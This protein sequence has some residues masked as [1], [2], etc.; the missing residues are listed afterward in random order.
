[1][2]EFIKY[3]AFVIFTTTF[4]WCTYH[5]VNIWTDLLEGFS[6]TAIW[7]IIRSDKN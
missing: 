7:Q 4:V 1:M 2:K 3:I 5:R 6:I